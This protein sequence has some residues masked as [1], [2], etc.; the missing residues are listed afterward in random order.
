MTRTN[1]KIAE[2][3]EGKRVVDAD[4]GTVGIL[5]D[6]DDGTGYVDPEPGLTDRIRSRLGWGT[7]EE[8]DYPLDP[9]AIAEITHDEIR[10]ARD[11]A[12]RSDETA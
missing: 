2:E 9:A 12:T 3:D 1:R 4:G 10:L 8:D 5:V 6:V 7:V 11:T